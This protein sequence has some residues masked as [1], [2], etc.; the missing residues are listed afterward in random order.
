MLR[1]RWPAVVWTLVTAWIAFVLVSLHTGWLNAFF[2]DTGHN[3][4]PG[5][6]FFPLERGW[7]NLTNGFSEF[8][9]FRSDYGPWATWLVYH[10]ALAVLLGPLF[11]LFAP[12]T[13]YWLW[14]ALSALMLGA[15]AYVLSRD[16]AGSLRQPLIFLLLLGAFP[17]YILWQSG[18]VQ[19]LLVLAVALI[20]AAVDGMRR[21]GS[22]RGNQAMLLAGLLLSLFSKPIVLAM[23]PL[24]LLLKQTR[25][26]ALLSLAIY[27]PVSLL[28][29]ALPAWNP[30]A[31][32]WAERW[33]LFTHPDVIA[34]TMN[35]YTNH[36]TVTR[37][38][39]DNAVHWL[40]MVGLTDFRFLHVDIYSLSALLDGWL[41][42][43]T[44]DALYR[45][46]QL[47]VLEV[48]LLIWF[49]RERRAQM[50]AAL[51][52]LMAAAVSLIL[53]YGLVWEYH[54]T[55]VLAVTAC[56]FARAERDWALRVVIAL[57]LLSW[58]PSLYI[59]LRAESMTSLHV[60]TILRAERVLPVLAIFL[61]LLGRAMV[62][63]LRNPE[64][65]RWLTAEPIANDVIV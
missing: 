56:L 63:A 5:I 42:T 58:A 2:Y 60:Q 45:I 21:D 32:S 65:L 28:A 19:S 35:V 27:L 62:L 7:L 3:Q 10:P 13:A 61:L 9:T 1:G 50:E 39:M 29:L 33:E 51:M 31:M 57:G 53:S 11:M 48:S 17:A 4:M 38:M 26:M 34:A 8:D 36:F 18:N 55:L 15:A 40:A 12:W 16:A 22:S 44:P 47:L 49:V 30:V 64:G 54:Y 24:L 46:P 25:R 37:P 23:L 52:T 6:D 14:T 43:R 59:F 20:F 41:Q